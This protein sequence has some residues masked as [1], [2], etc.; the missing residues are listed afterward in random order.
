M[1]GL[2]EKAKQLWGGDQSRAFKIGA[3]VFAGTLAAASSLPM[4]YYKNL[5]SPKKCEVLNVESNLG[6]GK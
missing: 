2:L 5:L 3:W 1:P 4:D 6:K